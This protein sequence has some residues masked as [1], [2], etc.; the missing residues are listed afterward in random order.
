MTLGTTEDRN[1]SAQQ[2]LRE[3]EEEMRNIS[4]LL[5]EEFTIP[6]VQISTE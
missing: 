1:A 5:D 2:M 4:R 3:I 6:R